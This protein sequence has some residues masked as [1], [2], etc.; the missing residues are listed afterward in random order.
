MTTDDD[1]SNGWEGAAET[2]IVG[3]SR[4]G[5]ATVRA[6]AQ[7]LPA[8]ASILDLGCGTGVPV[9]EALINDGFTIYG[10]DASP[11]LVAAFRRRFPKAPVACESV[12]ESAFFDRRF[13]GVVTIGLLFLLSASVQRRML[14]RVVSALNPAGRFLFTA[15]EQECMWTDVLTGRTSRSL[16][17]KAYREVLAGVGV[18]V[19]GSYVDEG[20]NYDTARLKSRDEIDEA[21]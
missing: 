16:G 5:V 13:D 15:P 2:L 1:R 7:A 11:S 19:V 14:R 3:R 17:A 9:S 6:W 10:V 21:V 4:I 8:G 12:E 20:K 18:A